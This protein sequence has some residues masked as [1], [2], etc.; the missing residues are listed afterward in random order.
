MSSTGGISILV[1]LISLILTGSLVIP[2]LQETSK[3][4]QDRYTDTNTTLQQEQNTEVTIEKTTTADTITIEIKNTGTT[5]VSLSSLTFLIDGK[6]QSPDSITVNNTASRT[7][8][9]QNET[10]VIT[11]NTQPSTVSKIY[12]YHNYFEEN[13]TIT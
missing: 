3:H 9:D 7:F 11:F 1:I 10:A 12:I 13:I 2:Q 5:T 8:I 6:Y 4:I